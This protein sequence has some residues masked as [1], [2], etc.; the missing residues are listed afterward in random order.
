MMSL[1]LPRWISVTGFH[2]RT[3]AWRLAVSGDARLAVGAALGSTNCETAHAGADGAAPGGVS[4]VYLD[5]VPDAAAVNESVR[6][7]KQ[8]SR[9]LGRDW[10]GFVNAVLR[11][12]LRS[13]EPVWP[14]VAQDP[15][16]ALSVRY[17]CPGWLAERWCRDWG[18]A[19]AEA[20]CRAT[21]ELP[22]TD[23]S[24]EYPE[25]LSDCVVGGTGCGE[26]RCQPD[27]DQRS[28]HSTGA[29]HL[30]DRSPRI[31]RGPFLCRR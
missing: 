19:R 25:N 3:G 24:C 22:P 17:S 28:G 4:S 8:Q 21:V 7:I 30:R 6:L 5:R 12:L 31:R 20:L 10:S 2:G 29:P 1:P 15:A 23:P 18:V 11:A 27:D 16:F 13:P 14:E 26:C 9:R